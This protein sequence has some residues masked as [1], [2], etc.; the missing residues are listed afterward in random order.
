METSNFIIEN[1]LEK[2]EIIPKNKILSKIE[3]AKKKNKILSKIELAKKKAQKEMNIEYHEF[4]SLVD[5]EAKAFLVNNLFG[6]KGAELKKKANEIEKNIN[7]IKN[8][9]VLKSILK[10]L[11]VFLSGFLS[12]L[13]PLSL[14]M[15]I[16]VLINKEIQRRENEKNI[17]I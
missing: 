11:S 2:I 6:E 13:I 15:L 16:Y 14:L 10:Y 17:S 7:Q 1:E 12:N 3:L 5:R 8:I 4:N 9:N